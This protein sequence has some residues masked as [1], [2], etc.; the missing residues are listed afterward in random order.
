MFLKFDN[1]KECRRVSNFMIDCWTLSLN[2]FAL[3]LKTKSLNN[4]S[5]RMNFGDSMSNALCVISYFDY[6]Q[7]ALYDLA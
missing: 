4:I 3:S 1:K 5:R 2:I 7:L 6:G